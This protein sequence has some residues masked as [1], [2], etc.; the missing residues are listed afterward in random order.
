MSIE[1]Y[2]TP[3]S[4]DAL[5]MKDILEFH[6]RTKLK[7]ISSMSFFL[8]TGLYMDSIRGA[9]EASRNYKATPSYDTELINVDVPERLYKAIEQ[10][11]S[12][13]SFDLK[14]PF[15]RSGLL[16]SL[17][18]CTPTRKAQAHVDDSIYLNF[19][20]Y[21]SPG[22]LYPVE[23]HL[24][25]PTNNGFE[26]KYFNPNTSTLHMIRRDISVTEVENA[27]CVGSDKSLVHTTRGAILL[28]VLWERTVIKYG[29]AGYRFA[30]IELGIVSQ[31]LSLI[32]ADQDIE[33]LN[34]GAFYDDKGTDL[35]GADPSLE[36]LGSVIW[37]GK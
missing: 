34:W 19:R 4:F 7:P 16:R 2:I 36:T 11:R 28:S 15:N 35:L 20:P 12:C 25:E 13:R 10:R 18:S 5:E 22:G 26:L 30:L 33:T 29:I 14:K 6:D 31:H 1:K 24:L 21:P 17:M 23:I 37:Y 27:L 3:H 9:Q 8:R 32:L